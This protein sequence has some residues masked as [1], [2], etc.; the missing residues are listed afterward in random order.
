MDD[1]RELT[2]N[3]ISLS[4]G[5]HGAASNPPMVLLHALGER[6]DDWSPVVDRFAETFQLFTLDLRGHGH[7]ERT[8]TYSFDAMCDDVIDLLAQ[9]NLQAVT[10][11]GHSTG[12]VVAYLVTIR[13][14][15]IVKSLIVEDVSPPFKRD[16]P[17]PKTPDNTDSLDFDWD[18]VP[19]IVGEVNAGNLQA[20]HGLKTIRARTLLI[21]GGPTSHIPQDKLVEV[22]SLI[23]RCDMTTIATGHHVHRTEPEQ[24]AA[25]V[26]GWLT[27]SDAAG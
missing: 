23:P 20:W 7:S 1:K 10:L 11:V 27:A 19:A 24:F 17:I 13:R 6:G 8:D 2:A 15:D 25:A 22:A 21:G 18:V 12:G 5:V 14:P 3:G 26:I 4:Y 9:L 16:H